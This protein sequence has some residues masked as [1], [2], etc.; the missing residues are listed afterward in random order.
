MTKPNCEAIAEE[1]LLQQGYGCYYPKIRAL[2]KGKIVVKRPLFPR[3]VFAFVDKLW[4][5]IRGTRGVS[6]LLM[7]DAGPATIPDSVID[8]LKAREDTNGFIVLSKE[9]LPERFQKGAQVRTTEGPLTGLDLIYD[10]MRD[11]ERVTVLTMLL[12]RQVPVVM[13]EKF[14]VAGQ[15]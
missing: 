14:L 8:E 7:N 1:N 3:Y 12:G 4:Y 10:G 5:S 9:K 15:V 2:Q 11:N 13:Q 6:Y